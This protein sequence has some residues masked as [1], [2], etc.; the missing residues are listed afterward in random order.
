MPAVIAAPPGT[1]LPEGTQE[2]Q[3]FTALLSRLIAEQWKI[4]QRTR[5]EHPECCGLMTTDF[6]GAGSFLHLDDSAVM[7]RLA[8]YEG[9]TPSSYANS[10]ASFMAASLNAADED[11][12]DTRDVELYA[13]LSRLAQLIGKAVGSSGAKTPKG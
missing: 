10:L 3:E 7:R 9:Q 8:P 13:Q 4:V 11:L 5:A 2:K 12:C 1:P 6:F